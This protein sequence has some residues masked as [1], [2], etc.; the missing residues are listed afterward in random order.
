MVQIYLGLLNSLGMLDHDC[1][2]ITEH[3]GPQ[4]LLN[5]HMME[6]GNLVTN[7]RAECWSHF[8]KNRKTLLLT[9]ILN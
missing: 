6:C 2:F 3:V 4:S 9:Q 1:H 8:I 7:D 5:L